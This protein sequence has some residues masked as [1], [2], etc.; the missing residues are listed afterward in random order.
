MSLQGQLPPSLDL[1]PHLSAHKYFFVCT[2]TVAAWD[3]L[4]L[5]PRSWRMIKGKDGWPVLKILYNFLRIFMPAEFV[6]VAV[7][8]FD[9]HFSQQSCA[10]FYLF[11]PICT[12]VLLAATSIVHVIRIHGIYDKNRTVLMGLSTLYAVQIVVTAICCGFYRYVPL[13]EGQGCIAGPKHNWVGI[14][15]LAPT[16]LYTATFALALNR[17]FQSRSMKPISLWK[18]MLRDGLNLYGAIWIVNMV[19]MLFWFIVKPTGPDDT[20]KTV[21]TSMAAVLT[22]SMTLRIILGVRGS[23]DHG[24]SFAGASTGASNTTRSHVF[25]A[26]RSHGTGGVPHTYDLSQVSKAAEGGGG[27]WN[28]SDSDGKSSVNGPKA[29]LP[30]GGPHGVDVGQDGVKI[31]INQEVEYDNY[32]RAK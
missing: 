18:L 17:S 25:S 21:V 13:L 30:V 6:V 32:P 9:T 16:L 19:N 5:S 8:F 11:E 2:L 23:L 29:I 31:T 27:E 28:L 15:W 14:Y 4:V 3:T 26:S 24:G 1:P 7:G 22:T 10:K 20:V 12:A